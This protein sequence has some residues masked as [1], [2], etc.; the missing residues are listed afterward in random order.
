M[1]LKQRRNLDYQKVFLLAEE[2]DSYLD[3]NNFVALKQLEQNTDPLHKNFLA[4]R[5]N[6]PPPLIEKIK[7]LLKGYYGTLS[8]VF[9]IFSLILTLVLIYFVLHLIRNILL[10]SKAAKSSGYNRTVTNKDEYSQLLEF[11]S[12]DE[13]ATE[14]DIKRSYRD[15]MKNYHPDTATETHN[16]EAQKDILTQAKQNYNR[17]LS[18]R[19]AAFSRKSRDQ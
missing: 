19:S 7:L 14:T 8:L 10:S 2:A 17:L 1:C 6:T 12:L 13:S 4:Q 9:V 5:F 11:F 18:L 3:R 15:F 16:S